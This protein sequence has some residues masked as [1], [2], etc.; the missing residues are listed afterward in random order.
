MYKLSLF[1]FSFSSTSIR[2]FHRVVDPQGQVIGRKRSFSRNSTRG[3]N[4][5]SA[6]MSDPLGTVAENDNEED[7]FDDN[8]TDSESDKLGNKGYLHVVLLF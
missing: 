5:G 8:L 3:G 7:N 4:A 2:A 1:S 6:A